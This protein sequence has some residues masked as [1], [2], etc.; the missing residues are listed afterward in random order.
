MTFFCQEKRVHFGKKS[1]LKVDNSVYAADKLVH[2]E[3]EFTVFFQEEVKMIPA[4]VSDGVIVACAVTFGDLLGVFGDIAVLLELVQYRIEEVE[5][6]GMVT[7]LFKLL[8]EPI[9]IHG[10]FA[11]QEQDDHRT[12]RAFEIVLK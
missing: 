8:R 3:Q 9:S 7:S 5:C 11:E 10:F 4:F 2:S 1:T 6:I 12:D